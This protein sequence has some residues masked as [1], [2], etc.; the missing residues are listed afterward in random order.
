M[1][2]PSAL[3]VLYRNLGSEFSPKAISTAKGRQAWDKGDGSGFSKWG[4]ITSNLRPDIS[5]EI[6]TPS[7]N[8]TLSYLLQE[9]YNVCFL[10]G[11]LIRM[12]DGSEKPI[13]KIALLDEVVSAEGVPR[14]VLSTMV[15]PYE[16]NLVR[17]KIWGHQHLTTTPEHPILTK[18][19]YIPTGEL[20]DNDWVVMPR[21]MAQT[22]ES[23][24]PGDYIPTHYRGRSKRFGCRK[25]YTPTWTAKTVETITA[26][27]PDE[28]KLDRAFGRL[29]GL[30]L[31][32]GHALRAVV[33][34]T[35][36]QHEKETLVA[37]TA[38]LLEGLGAT[39][40]FQERDNHHTIAVSIYGAAWA[41]LFDALCEKGAAGKRLHR[42]LCAGS[43]EF[44]QA[45]FE[46]WMDGDGHEE[47]NGRKTG[48][49]ISHT[50]AMN[51]YD[52]AQAVGL[53]PCIK[54]RPGSI[55]KGTDRY[56]KP[57]WEVR[58][59]R[60]IDTSLT[61]YGVMSG[62]GTGSR[63]NRTGF[64]DI[65]T[66]DPI[67]IPS[68]GRC[69]LTA[70]YAWRKVREVE[71]I[72]NSE[73]IYVYNLCVDV[74]NS[75]IAEGIGVHNCSPFSLCINQLAGAAAQDSM[76]DE[77]PHTII[78]N[79]SNDALGEKI[80]KV[81]YDGF[82][83]IKLGKTTFMR[84]RR[85][86]ITGNCFGEPICQYDGAKWWMT[87]YQLLPTFEMLRD[88]SNDTYKQVR[89][90]ASL[91]NNSIAEWNVPG[92]ICRS[93]HLDDHNRPYGIPL[94]QLVTTEY[95][96][97]VMAVEDVVVGGRTR[98]A[99]KLKYS[100]GYKDSKVPIPL[101]DLE[102][103]RARHESEAIDVLTNLWMR[104]NYEDVTE[105]QGD[106][107][108]IATLID[109]VLLWTNR[110]KRA[111]GLPI[112]PE[113]QKSRGL[114]SV[115]AEYARTINIVRAEDACFIEEIGNHILALRGYKDV[116]WCVLIP[117][118]GETELNRA[119]RAN[120]MRKAGYI[121]NR[122]WCSMVGIKDYRQA[123]KDA[124]E[125]IKWRV[126]QG[127]PPIGDMTSVPSTDRGDV[128]GTESPAAGADPQAG[129]D[130]RKTQREGGKKPTG[131]KARRFSL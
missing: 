81:L 47:A 125:D 79:E 63:A 117:P 19:G 128:V 18:R 12:A 33:S 120:A 9:M 39:P 115:D 31:A 34:W 58:L 55:I 91:A 72:K 56:R 43:K 109:V 17:L 5:I 129:R 4:A 65:P 41:Y 36:G 77:S 104:A 48:V 38:S 114:E 124:E 80:Y 92:F 88:P 87:G 3:D 52:I 74:D 42:D 59:N 29:I 15:R 28:I 7:R 93:A 62:S 89:K 21:Y 35:F 131:A 11:T 121:G 100:V 75:Y 46:G 16:S 27:L 26:P 108:G 105:V 71:I 90:G 24:R 44:L 37:E 69:E 20:N 45:V 8:E 107:A 94:G 97:M 49:T 112:D 126:S 50:L 22:T 130:R 73:K 2:R 61:C 68:N 60:K 32:E 96:G 123:R 113:Q 54:L 10:P 95:R 86:L 83:R 70:K 84:N 13:E 53:Q 99:M 98:A 111:A 110:M 30:Y 101:E 1:A 40:H 116:D 66:K 64:D 78:V 25:S 82:R 122:I 51:M 102:A 76:A 85:N 103:F 127:L 23:I 57:S 118:L 14:Q 6:E 67:L 106:P 119:N